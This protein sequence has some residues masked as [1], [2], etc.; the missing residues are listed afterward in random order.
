MV[1]Q[2]ILIS[3]THCILV[4]HPGSFYG[5]LICLDVRSLRKENWK[6]AQ[7][8]N[9][10][11]VDDPTIRQLGFNLSWQ[12]W[13][14]LDRFQTVQGHCGACKKKWN[15][16]PLICVLVARIKRCPTLLTL[17]LCCCLADQLLL[18]VHMQKEEVLVESV[19][20]KIKYTDRNI[21]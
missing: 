14:L 1:G 6:S 3:L 17:V 9:S 8:V 18:P 19:R 4:F 21:V 20:I 5:N 7:V 13:S 15:Q 12:Q 11:L 2:F 10:F 16:A